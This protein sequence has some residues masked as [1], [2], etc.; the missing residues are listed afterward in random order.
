MEEGKKK[1]YCNKNNLKNQI[2]NENIALK[3]KIIEIKNSIDNINILEYILYIS[4]IS[5]K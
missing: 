2:L 5:E 1:V 3:S 4:Y